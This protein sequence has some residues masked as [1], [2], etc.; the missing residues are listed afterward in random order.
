MKPNVFITSLDTTQ[1][2]NRTHEIKLL[3]IY[4]KSDKK[5]NIVDNPDKAHIIL[6]GNV[7]DEDGA[8]ILSSPII[9]KFPGKC[10]SISDTDLPLFLNHGIYTSGNNRSFIGW[11]RIRTGSYTLLPDKYMNPYIGATENVNSISKKYLFSF[12]GRNCHRVRNQILNLDFSRQDILIE[13][14]SGVF[15]RWK[16]N[17]DEEKKQQHF[18][19]V[20]AKSKFSLC[21]RGAISNSIRLFESLQMGVAPI[22]IADAFLFPKGPDWE[23]FSIIIKE[24]DINQLESIVSSYE[25]NYVEMGALARQCYHNYFSEESYFNY[26]VDNCIDIQKTQIIPEEWYWKMRKGYL[27]YLKVKKQISS[28]VYKKILQ[29]VL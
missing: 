23:K 20:L 26:I 14:S 9:K 15:D 6:I 13:D 29:K 2:G 28:V 16:S 1:N 5:Y 3:E 12:I 7:D 19:E 22:I 25:A 4:Q 24:K 18:F 21:P 17:N 8:K 11:K 27:F 10:F